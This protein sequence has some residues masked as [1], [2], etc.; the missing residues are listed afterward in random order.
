MSLTSKLS[1]KRRDALLLAIFYLV[2]GILQISILPIFDVRMLWIG[3]LA[4]LSLIAAYG[5]L[6]ARRWSVWLVVMLFFPQLVFGAYTLEENIS[7][8]GFS[9]LDVMLLN[10]SMVV[11]IILS[12]ISF[13][14]VTAKRKTFA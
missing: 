1:I 7:L 5:L 14:Y 10:I 12:A 6:R 2:V 3:G 11:F 4:I 9:G 8:Y 13:I